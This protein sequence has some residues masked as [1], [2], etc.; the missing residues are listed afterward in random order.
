MNLYAYP[1]SFTHCVHKKAGINEWNN[2]CQSISI[3][4]AKKVLE[5]SEERPDEPI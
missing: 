1:G 5:D 2:F 4:V 3:T